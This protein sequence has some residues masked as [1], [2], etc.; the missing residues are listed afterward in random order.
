MLSEVRKQLEI[1]HGLRLVGHDKGTGLGAY[2]QTEARRADAT[3]PRRRRVCR[4]GR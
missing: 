4:R 2:S 3:P 1:K